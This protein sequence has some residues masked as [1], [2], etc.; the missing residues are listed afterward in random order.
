MTETARPAERWLK[1]EFYGSLPVDAELFAASQPDLL[2]DLT[3]HLARLFGFTHLAHL[4]VSEGKTYQDDPRPASMLQPVT[5]SDSG[6]EAQ[7]VPMRA[8]DE[9]EDTW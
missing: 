1:V 3:G 8:V 7:R 4:T 9:A 6:D 5:F 2:P